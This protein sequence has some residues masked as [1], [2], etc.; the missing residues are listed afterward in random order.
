MIPPPPDWGQKSFQHIFFSD[1]S[2]FFR[3]CNGHFSQT[4]SLPKLNTL[5]L[6]L[7]SSKDPLEAEIWKNKN[8]LNF[9]NTL[10]LTD[11]ILGVILKVGRINYDNRISDFKRHDARCNDANPQ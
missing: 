11:K 4:Q 3:L 1:L 6:S 9:V 10:C 8:N 2:A 7:V 5:D